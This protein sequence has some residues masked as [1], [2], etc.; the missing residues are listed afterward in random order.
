M[1]GLIPAAGSGSRM[2]SISIGMPK[3]LLSIDGKPM[4]KYAI[5]EMVAAGIK[6]IAVIIHPEKEIIKD[7]LSKLI[8]SNFRAINLDIHFIYQYERSGLMHAVYLSKDFINNTPFAL[9][10]PDNLVI[11]RFGQRLDY[12]MLIQIVIDQNINSIGVVK[13]G[14]HNYAKLF[15][16]CGKVTYSRISASVIRINEISKKNDNR[17]TLLDNS[18]IYK[19]FGRYFLLPEI[20]TYIEELLNNV[21]LYEY[22]DVPVLQRLAS[23]GKLRGI[24]CD[25]MIFDTGNPMG[26]YAARK[27]LEC[28]EPSEMRQ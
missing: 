14:D 7:Y 8:K 15:S 9:F 23:E 28:N 11:P 22:D 5:E 4:I 21:N 16:D 27:Y 13:I 10:L 12:S 17:L 3:E 6:E 26:Y 20:F 25:S 19:T 1:K 24:I 18:S 2:N